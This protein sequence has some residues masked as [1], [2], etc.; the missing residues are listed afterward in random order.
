MASQFDLQTVAGFY[1]EA[2]GYLSPLDACLGRLSSSPGDRELL[3]EV[4]RLTHSI[5]G[6]SAVVGMPQL[7]TLSGDLESFVEDILSGVLDW[8]PTT[9]E[10]MREAVNLIRLQ[11]EIGS[12]LRCFSSGLAAFQTLRPLTR[13]GS[14]ACANRISFR[15]THCPLP[16]IVVK[17]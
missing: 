12:F 17:A 14:P 15:T 1:E 4:H 6:A 11:L 7:T 8:E 9:L 16:R 13:A 5:R 3:D 10:I 2:V